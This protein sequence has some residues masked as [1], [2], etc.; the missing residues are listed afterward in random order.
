MKQPVRRGSFCVLV[1]GLTALFK[2]SGGKMNCLFH[3]HLLLLTSF[4]TVDGVRQE[5]KWL[6]K[7]WFI[8]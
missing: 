5:K 4:R 7:C 6:F 2:K 3:R 1:Y 8:A